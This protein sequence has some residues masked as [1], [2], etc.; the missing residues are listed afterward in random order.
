MP[1]AA[2]F[3]SSGTCRGGES[4]QGGL[5]TVWIDPKCSGESNM[6]GHA[7]SKTRLDSPG[8]LKSAFERASQRE[9]MK[10]GYG[11]ANPLDHGLRR[12]LQ[13][14]LKVSHWFR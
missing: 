11:D 9:A 10:A 13:L 2:L 14:M 4:D 5:R 6:N 3:P 1:S 12:C 8:I 7:Q